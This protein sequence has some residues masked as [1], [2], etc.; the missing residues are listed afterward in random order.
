MAAID[1]NSLVGEGLKLEQEGKYD[2]AQE[3]FEAAIRDFQRYKA[4]NLV[5]AQDLVDEAN[6]YSALGNLLHK[7][8]KKATHDEGNGGKSEL[9]K[10]AGLNHKTAASLREDARIQYEVDNGKNA[11]QSW[12][13]LNWIAK[14]SE[15]ARAAYD[16]KHASLHEATK[17]KKEKSSED[18]EAMRLNISSQDTFT[19][20][21][22]AMGT[23]NIDGITS[24]SLQQAA[25]TDYTMKD[26]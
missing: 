3:K 10:N 6:A 15:W 7:K 24:S 18:K 21:A 9:F 12:I 25:T 16:Y 8:A 22:Y 13:I 26:Y 1:L 17:D 20:A 19:L 4:H 23:S 5:T 11:Q 2:K 14:A